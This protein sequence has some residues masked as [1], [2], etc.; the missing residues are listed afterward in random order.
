MPLLLHPSLS[1]C[2]VQGSH[3]FLDIERDRYFSLSPSLGAS[4]RALYQG[5]SASP[6]AVDALK[7]MAIVVA[8][9]S[10][11]PL[12]PCAPHIATESLIDRPPLLRA[13]GPMPGLIWSLARTRTRLRRRGLNR[14]LR[15]LSGTRRAAPK[16]VD[17][18]DAR[19]HRIAD[20]FERLALLATTHDQCLVRS[21]ALARY[22]AREG[23]GPELVFAVR[24]SP[25]K[26][27]CW[28]ECRGFLVNDR[29]ERV[30]HFMPIPRL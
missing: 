13:F 4:F 16:V 5:A 15:E 18:A 26:A 23:L 3:I 9:A 8:D 2:E 11:S 1:F 17:N 24:L 19:L 10:G 22:L 14:L 6:N 12:A 20:A 21:F 28:V 25:F 30:H 7:A 27:H 29:I